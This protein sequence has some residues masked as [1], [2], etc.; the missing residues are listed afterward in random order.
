MASRSQADVLFPPVR[1][2]AEVGRGVT[3]APG[4]LPKRAVD[5]VG[6]I[7]LIVLLAPLM[8]A[9]AVLIKL[10]SRGA[11]IFRQSRAGLGGKPFVMYK[12]RTMIDSAEDSRQAVAHLNEKD[13]PVFKIANDPRLTCV[14]K[15]LRR[16]SADELPQLFN[17]LS[18]QMSLVGP[19]PL[20]LPEAMSAT[21]RARRRMEV[22]PGMTCLWQISGRSELSYDRW[23]D[24]DLYY[25]DHQTFLLDL[26][27]MFQTVP[28]VISAR[29]AY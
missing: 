17:V 22:K 1:D 3:S 24:L 20:W 6:S 2:R 12:F 21:G 15:L 9:I 14:G 23:I 5:V 18:G 28:A 8:L 4:G 7:L 25:I 13:G 11:V 16:S 27:I 26:L 19:R 29:G 10:T